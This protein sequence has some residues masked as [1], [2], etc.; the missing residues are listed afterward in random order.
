MPDVNLERLQR[1]AQSRWG[2]DL[3]GALRMATGINMD[4]NGIANYVGGRDMNAGLPLT[5]SLE[6]ILEETQ[7]LQGFHGRNTL[8]VGTLVPK[9]MT[10]SESPHTIAV[11]ADAGVPR[12]LAPTATS[13]HTST[14]RWAFEIPG[15]TGLNWEVT[16]LCSPM[17]VGVNPGSGTIFPQAGIGLRLQDDGVTRR[18]IAINNNIAYGSGVQNF[19]VWSCAVAGTGFTN[20]QMSSGAAFTNPV[21]P[22]W[23]KVRL[24]GTVLEGWIWGTNE[25][26]PA[27]GQ[28][29]RYK[30]GDLD[31]DAG[32]VGSNIT[33][34][35]TGSLCLI[36]A[37]LGNDSR[38][39]VRWPHL[40]YRVLD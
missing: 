36:A 11:S 32:T 7:V 18:V 34:I 38:S 31:V 27:R 28:T 9:V 19:G 16:Y 10:D 17:N 6:E 37:H 22:H 39:E 1:L 30:L 15:V 29:D 3:Q 24:V 26:F 23:V 25:S 14:M 8:N 4:M 33:P 40:M 5:D 12:A 35:T 13:A 2:L 20:R 21:F